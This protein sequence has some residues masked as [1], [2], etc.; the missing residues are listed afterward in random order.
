MKIKIKKGK[1]RGFTIVELLIYMGLLSI[2]LGILTTI[3]VSTLNVQLESRSSSAV[4]QDGNYIL[5]KLAVDI[6]KA[7]SISV[8]NALGSTGDNFTIVID[9]VNYNYSIDEDE[10]LVLTNN[11]GENILNSFDS[12]IASFSAQR[13]GN[14]GKVE[15]NLNINF[16]ITSRIHEQ[17][18]YETKNFQTNVGLR[19][20]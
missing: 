12:R 9:G 13:L 2:L 7:T 8:P 6:H 14:V 16:T 3:F 18:G 5:A 11:L 20:Q 15:D 19:R 17:T 4:V 1:Q 10:N